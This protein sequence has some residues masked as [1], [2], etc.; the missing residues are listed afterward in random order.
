M[1]SASMSLRIVYLGMPGAFSSLP[2]QSLLANNIEITAVAMTKS[3]TAW[4][5]DHRLAVTQPAGH[6][7]LAELASSANIPLWELADV[8]SDEVLLA[9]QQLHPDLVLV[10]CF[11]DRLPER[12]LNTPRYGCY[13]LHPS[14]LP[15]YRGPAPM[16]WQF[17]MDERMT[18][19]SLHKMIGEFDSGEIVEAREVVLQPGLSGMQADVRLA[20]VGGELMQGLIEQIRSGRLSLMPQSDKRKSHYPWPTENDF[21]LDPQWPAEHAFNFMRGTAHWG[22]PYFVMSPGLDLP[23]LAQAQSFDHSLTLAAECDYQGNEILIQFSPG[24]LRAV[25]AG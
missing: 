18:G 16:F 3:Q 12:F 24:V 13:N 14:L 17:Y 9:L 11:P 22:R 1:S 10:A 15:A 8:N 7:N 4:Q 6:I 21:Y 25:V 5:P 20:T 2:L 23:P 19:V